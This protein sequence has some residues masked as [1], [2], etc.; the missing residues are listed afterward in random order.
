MADLKGSTATAMAQ[1]FDGAERFLGSDAGADRYGSARMIAKY[2]GSGI[3]NQQFAGQ[4]PAAAATTYLTGSNL[5]IPT[6][7]RVIA[8]T[9]ARWR[10][11][12]VKTAAG[13][14]AKSLLVKWGVNGT[15][16]D[17]TVMTFALPVGTAVID[18]GDF[19]LRV[20]FRSVGA[21]SAAVLYGWLKFWHVLA[22]TGLIN[23]Q[24]SLVKVTSAGF[25]SDVDVSKLGLAF[26]AGVA[27][28]WTFQ[29]MIAELLNA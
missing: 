3:R 21:G 10:G 17:A 27:E 25:N 4:S 18:D 2:L 28:A 8:G 22:T 29:A 5:N 13:T 6:S 19:E 11:S 12:V 20:G 26:T 9:H 1:P 16:A 7:E 14:A 23:V 15:T 24:Q